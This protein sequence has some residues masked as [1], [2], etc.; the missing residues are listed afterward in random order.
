M[1]GK[2][3]LK[4][5]GKS[6]ENKKFV[7]ITQQ[8]F[9]LLPQANFPAN[10]LNFHSGE[11]DEIES[12]L[13]SYIFSTLTVISIGN[14]NTRSDNSAVLVSRFSSNSHPILSRFSADFRPRKFNW[15]LGT[16]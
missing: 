5:K 12:K 2:V 15:T 16:W 6:F 7:D 4:C 1:G 3:Y 11:E 13:S 9:A 8:C 14:E 10:D